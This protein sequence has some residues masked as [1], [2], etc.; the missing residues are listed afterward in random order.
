LGAPLA[1]LA[2]LG[3]SLS[4]LTALGAVLLVAAALALLTVPDAVPPT[5]LSSGVPLSATSIPDGSLSSGLFSS[6]LVVVVLS[7]DYRVP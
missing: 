7:H 2:L 4:L 1:L 3:P 5:L 6:A